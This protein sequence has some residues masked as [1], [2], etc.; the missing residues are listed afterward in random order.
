MAFTD[1][2]ITLIFTL[3]KGQFGQTG[4]N[5]VTVTGL[6][7]SAKIVKTGAAAVCECQ[8]RIFGLTP[9]VYNALTSIYPVTQGMQQNT[10]T[11]QAGDSTSGLSTVFVG[12]ILVA[13]IDLN[14][15]P[16][17]VMNIVAQTALLQSLNPSAVQVSYPQGVSV[18]Q[19]T[20]AL[21]AQMGLRFEPNNVT[22]QLPTMTFSGTARQQ[23]L[24]ILE[25]AP[26]VQWNSGDNGV[27][28]IWQDGGPRTD[29][30][31]APVVISYE[32]DMIG[33]PSFSNLGLGIRCAYNPNVAYYGQIQIVSS[34]Q[35][36][37]LN[38]IW[39]VF[40]LTHT[41]ES[42]LPGGQWM[43]EIQAQ[44]FAALAP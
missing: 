21:A 28:A 38:G 12:Q 19:A 15:Q 8:L 14:S 37:N 22:A 20:Q 23:M 5:T 29:V 24:K 34:L 16:D 26:T 13:Q 18:V 42:E 32:N 40:G 31:A 6:R 27:L 44:N 35:V 33:Y 25:A 36:A 2:Q 30:G 43:T 7:V 1:K 11:V 9:T 39:T 10:V 3:G 41:L 17:S 4:A